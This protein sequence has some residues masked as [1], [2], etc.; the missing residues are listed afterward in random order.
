M[1]KYLVK[2]LNISDLFS[3]VSAKYIYISISILMGF[4]GGAMVKNPC[5]NAGDTGEVSEIF[6][7]AKSPGVGNGSPLQYSCLGNPM[8]RQA[9][10]A[11]VH[12]VTKE[13]DTTEHTHSSML[14]SKKER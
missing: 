9:W 14:I 4:P 2:C 10:Q 8:H 6:G 11:T 3:N 1:L 7:W 12:G 13:P 5:V